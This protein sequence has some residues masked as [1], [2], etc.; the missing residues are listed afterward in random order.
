VS[1]ALDLRALAARIAALPS[2]RRLVALAGP[3]AAGKSHTADALVAELR[4]LGRSVAVLPM[5]GYHYDDAVLRARGLLP[6]KGAPE[7][8]DADGLAHMLWRLGRN[9]AAEIAV[10]VFDRELEIARAGARIIPRETGIVLVEGNYLLLDRAPWS[11]LAEHFDLTAMIGADLG[12]IEARLRRRWRR[13]SLTETEIERKVAENDLPNAATV[14][15]G[16]RA[17]DIMLRA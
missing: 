10:P 15:D 9:E 17:A 2:G 4:A 1:E 11:A 12:V 3:P 8:F 13:A 14:I 16:S 5:D 6:R 7:T